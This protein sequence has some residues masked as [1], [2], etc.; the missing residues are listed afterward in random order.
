[1]PDLADVA[2]PL[3][4]AFAEY[5]RQIEDGTYPAEEH[6]YVMPAEEKAKFV[7][8]GNGEISEPVKRQS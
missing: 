3:K 5:V 6:Q 2:T 1:M 4:K 8:G 7:A